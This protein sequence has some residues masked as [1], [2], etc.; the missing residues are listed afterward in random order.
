LIWILIN[1]ITIKLN[2]TKR[3]Y[4]KQNIFIIT[5]YFLSKKTLIIVFFLMIIKLILNNNQIKWSNYE[6]IKGYFWTK[7]FNKL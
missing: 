7:R 5:G 2:N 4:E 1:N 6:V 3:G